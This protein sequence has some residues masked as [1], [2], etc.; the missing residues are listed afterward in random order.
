MIPAGALVFRL[1]S[2]L[3]REFHN[4]WMLFD[5]GFEDL[6]FCICAANFLIHEVAILQP[7][8]YSLF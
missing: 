6:S 5:D 1:T 7:T 4:I 3:L 2:I 8:T